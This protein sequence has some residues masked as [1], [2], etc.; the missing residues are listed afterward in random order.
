MSNPLRVL[1]ADDDPRHRGTVTQILHTDPGIEVVATAA[2]GAQVLSGLRGQ[3]VDVVLLDIR[4][5]RMDGLEALRQVR[6][7]SSP[8]AVLMLTTFGEADYVRTAIAEG[9]DGFLLKSGDP[10]QLIRAVRA[11]PQGEMWLSPAVAEMV[12]GELRAERDR[13]EERRRAN[14]RLAQLSPREREVVELVAG[15]ATN[16]EIGERLHL[17]ESTVKAYLGAAMTRLDARNRVDAAWAVW[18]ARE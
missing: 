7:S 11:A 2:D 9:A 14:R 13:V 4:M 3:A 18:S 5:P 1:V 17:S 8:P 15:G 10:V 16:A 12:A 6:R